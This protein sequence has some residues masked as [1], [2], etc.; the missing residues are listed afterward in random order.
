MSPTAAPLDPA[1]VSAIIQQ[2]VHRE[3]PLLPIL[4]DIQTA[5]G[6]VPDAARAPIAD[7]LNITEAELH[8]VISFYHDFRSKPAGARVLKICRAEA[9]QAMGANAMSEKVL[10]AL[11]LGWHET[12]PDGA[13]T[14][15]PIYCLGL[16][17]CA[18]AA[19]ID[20]RVKGRVTAEALLAEVAP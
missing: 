16:C 2:N 3:G 11:G 5:F 6:C 14:V 9:C 13:I 12:T 17:A 18:P 20:G 10:T 8:G 19:M 7:A 4:H 15:E 1:E